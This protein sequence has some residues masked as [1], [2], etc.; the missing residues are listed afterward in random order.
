MACDNH[1]YENKSLT[2]YSSANIISIISISAGWAQLVSFIV[3]KM[4]LKP[5][6]TH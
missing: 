6:N 5:Y 3:T 1:I 2:L 4:V